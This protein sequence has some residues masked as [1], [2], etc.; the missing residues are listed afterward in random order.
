MDDATHDDGCDTLRT[1]PVCSLSPDGDTDQGLCDMAG[2]VW[3]WVQDWY[4]GCYDCAQCPNAYYCDGATQAPDDGS[5]WEVPSSYNRVK[6]GGG[7]ASQASD[8][9]AASR[10]YIG[11][12]TGYSYTGVRCAR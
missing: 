8:L 9:R 2:N 11:L 5:A 1:A 4:H 6:R 3:E 10:A 12:G 7:F